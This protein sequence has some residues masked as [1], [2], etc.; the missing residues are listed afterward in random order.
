MLFHLYDFRYKLDLTDYVDG[1]R[2]LRTMATNRP[3][4]HPQ[5]I[6]EQGEQ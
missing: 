6:C 1:V 4:V 2:C 5:V 3:T